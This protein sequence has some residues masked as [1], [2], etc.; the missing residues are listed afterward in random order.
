MLEERKQKPLS[1]AHSA[2]GMTQRL[3]GVLREHLPGAAM[4]IPA[5]FCPFR[6]ATCALLHK[7]GGGGGETGFTSAAPQ[8]E[9]WLNLRC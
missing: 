7:G 4:T 5:D 9:K 3:Q 6:S 2:P 1:P 8:T